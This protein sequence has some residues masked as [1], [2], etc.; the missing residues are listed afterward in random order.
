MTELI[1]KGMA[2]RRHVLGYDHVVGTEARKIGFE[3]P[4]QSLI[5]DAALGHVRARHDHPA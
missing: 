4:F 5:A 2:I 1:D 3:E